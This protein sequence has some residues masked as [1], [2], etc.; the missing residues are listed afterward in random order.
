MLIRKPQYRLGYNGIHEIKEH[1]WLSNYNFTGLYDRKIEAPFIPKVSDNFDKKYCESPDK[2]GNDTMERYQKY[3]MH[4]D[5]ENLFLNYT[6]VS[7]VPDDGSAHS[8]AKKYSS[9]LLKGKIKISNHTRTNSGNVNTKVI[10]TGS[11]SY[12]A[13]SKEKNTFYR[14]TPNQTR[15]KP[16]QMVVSNF[17]LQKTYMKVKDVKPIEKLPSIDVR[18][19]APKKNLT[20]SPSLNQLGKFSKHSTISANSTG[21]SNTSVNPAHRRSGSTNNFNY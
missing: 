2:I 7:N 8:P 5:F 6:Y 14:M 21:S 4:E 11:T 3:Y 13:F 1:P 9:N 17:E 16:Q 12:G 20:Y 18:K 19:S 15:S 10:S